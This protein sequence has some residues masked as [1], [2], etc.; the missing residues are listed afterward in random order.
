MPHS[1]SHRRPRRKSYVRS[2]R[3]KKRGIWV[4]IFKWLAITGVTFGI[5]CAIGVS[6][7]YYKMKPD[8][9]DVNVLRDVQLQMPLRIYT[10]DGLLISEYGEKRREPIQ[11]SAVPQH[12]K[13]AIIAAEDKRFYV[14]PGVDYQ[15][16][17]RAFYYLLKTGKKGPGGS[18]ITMQVARNFFL[19]NEK[20]YIRKTKEI[21]LSFKIESELDKDEILELYI[22]KIY[23]GN[24]SYGFAAASKVYYGK[25]IGDIELAEAA[26]LAGLPK[27]PSTFNPIVNPD[28]ALLRRDYVLGRMNALGMIGD[29]E[30]AQA[31]A[32]PVSAALHYSRPEAEANYV[33]EMV[34]ERIQQLYGDSWATAGFNVYTTIRSA[35]Q[36]AA[37]DALRDALFDYES[38][39]GYVGP[40]GAVDEAT[41]SDPALLAEN[42]NEYSNRGGMHPAAVVAV[43]EATAILVTAE[44]EEFSI[45]LEDVLWAR[46][47]I[48]VDELGAEI[49]AV[50]DV[51]NVGDVIHLQIRA[52]GSARFVQEPKIEGAFVALEPRTGKVLALVGGF[53]YFRSKFNRATQARRQPGS[54]IKPFIY[55]AALENGDT[56]ATIY[57]DAPVVFHDAALEGEWRPQN[58]SGR[59]FG[60]TRLREALVK[61]RNLVSVRVLREIGIP[62]AIDYTQRF[63]F[64]EADLPPDLSLALG[65]ASVTPMELT[66]AFAIFAN[67]GYKVPSHFIQRIEDPRGDV[68]Y[69]TPKV[70]LCAD[71]QPDSGYELLAEVEA[72]TED[73]QTDTDAAASSEDQADASDEASQTEP[74]SEVSESVIA[75]E[76]A[77]LDVVNA[78]RVIDE[79]NAYIMGSMMRDV[80][81]RGTARRAGEAL[82]RKD[83]AGKTGTSNNQ[84]D[85][86]F[87]GFNSQVVAAAWVGS[88]G[89]EPLGKKEAG[90]VA[91][92]P[93]WS[94]FIGKILTGVPEDEF[95]PPSGIETIRVDATTGE[96]ASG[97]G[98]LMELFLEDTVPESVEEPEIKTSSS[99]GSAVTTAVPKSN[100]DQKNEV[101][102]L[103]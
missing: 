74:T 21:F 29:K 50:S 84:L 64:R 66:S 27:A 101:E 63:G 92:L 93:M 76:L 39:H 6:L 81:S 18:T 58:Y 54:T 33:G 47:R 70:V 19:T 38:R 80:V 51:L 55:S 53:D 1:S 48:G 96:P 91:A 73:D 90:G 56:A 11:I 35:N 3:R 86:W 85:A 2:S 88:D 16:L 30:F 102:S 94:A 9:P 46:Q 100:R 98:T 7:L 89:L 41:L 67:G 61:S 75:S 44:G 4:S 15:G 34:R 28:R 31:R 45:S 103:F 62:A 71:C 77:E 68:L 13:D 87:T 49:V 14:H 17:M 72:I 10:E 79:R 22:N 78:P 8:L 23:L 69:T 32:L 25:K 42:L 83:L 99:G 37:N 82:G 97:E 26:M 65:N 59:F 43:D 12:L 24:R 20:T 57:N 40:I 36:I 52:D 60:P 5:L 95:T